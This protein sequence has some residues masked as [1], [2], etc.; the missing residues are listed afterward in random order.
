LVVIDDTVDQGKCVN[1]LTQNFQPWHKQVV[2]QEGKGFILQEDSTSC[3]TAGYA[4]WW[5]ESHQI[6]GFEYWL[7]QNPN[8][9]PIEHLWGC[10]KRPIA[11]RRHEISDAQQLRT[12]MKE[13]WLKQ[14]PELVARLA[15]GMKA[16][17]EVVVAAKGGPTKYQLAFFFIS[18]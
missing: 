3:Y 18:S 8:L 10:L 4:R 13:E 14:I 12:T 9:N 6:R 1:I 5:K 15:R 16:K 7:A 2:E 11:R 17:C